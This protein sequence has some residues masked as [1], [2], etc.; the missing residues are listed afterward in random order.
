MS[1][2]FLS[3]Y[4]QPL[5][6]ATKPLD[7]GKRKSIRP[8]GNFRRRLKYIYWRLL[9]MQGKPEAIARGLA[10]GVFAGFFPLFG[11][12]LIIGILLAVLLRGNKIAAT[13]GT[14]IS[15]PLTYVPIFAFNF[16]VGE[17]LLNQDELANVSFQ[18]WQEFRELG[19]EIVLTLFVGCFAVGLVCAV[20]SYWLSVK[21][22]YRL[23]TNRSLQHQKKR[24]SEK[25]ATGRHRID[26]YSANS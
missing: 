24:C 11:L 13:A 23:R 8:R 18:S 14:W 4:P 17:W 10:C 2:K 22:I 3:S 9:R 26:H 16:H 6:S 20:V 19:S 1:R 15:N 5:P 12:Q 25:A 21:L 7:L